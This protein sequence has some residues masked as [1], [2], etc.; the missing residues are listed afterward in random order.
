MATKDPQQK[1]LYAWESTN[2]W[3][4]N[5]IGFNQAKSIIVSACKLYKVQPPEI[6]L[7]TTR[8]LPWACPAENLISLQRDKYLNIPIA[9][10]E[11]AHHIVY[12]LHGARPQDHGRTF[13][14]IY[15]DLLDKNEFPRYSQAK[16]YGL[17]WKMP[18]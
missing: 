18:K 6:K 7:H 13:L 2:G 14:G 1:R 16:A 17:R 5:T 3:E 11:A 15:L 12:N 10:H 4:T 9:L 8:A